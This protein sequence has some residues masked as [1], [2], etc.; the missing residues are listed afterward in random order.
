MT[1]LFP[2]FGFVNDDLIELLIGTA[3]SYN[4]AVPG[5]MVPVSTVQLNEYIII[6]QD[7]LFIPRG[8]TLSRPA[9]QEACSPVSIPGLLCPLPRVPLKPAQVKRRN[10]DSSEERV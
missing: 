8:L 6:R 10:H 2:D 5:R 1:P 3:Y 7:Y 4:I 9:T